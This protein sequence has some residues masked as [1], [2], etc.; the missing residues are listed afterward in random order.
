[1]FKP[2]F[3]AKNGKNNPTCGFSCFEKKALKGHRNKTIHGITTTE[4]SII[5]LSDIY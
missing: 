1:M 3:P 5:K 4:T 2:H